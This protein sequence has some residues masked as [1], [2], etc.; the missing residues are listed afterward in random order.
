MGPSFFPSSLSQG[1]DA[2]SPLR[3][4]GKII[5]NASKLCIMYNGR[6]QVVYEKWHTERK[7]SCI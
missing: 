2:E 1:G 6:K 5:Y 3:L 7:G 4:L